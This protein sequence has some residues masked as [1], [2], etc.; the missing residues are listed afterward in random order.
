MLL[1]SYSKI[2]NGDQI[3]WQRRTD[4]LALNSKI[5]VSSG[6]SKYINDFMYFDCKNILKSNA[7]SPEL[8]DASWIP[9]KNDKEKTIKFEFALNQN[10]S[11]IKIYQNF[12]S[13]KLVK[14]I[15]VKVNECTKNFNLNGLI[16]EIAIEQ[17]NVKFIEIKILDKLV[18]NE[19][20]SEIEIFSSSPSR[21]KFMTILNDDNFVYNKYYYDKIDLKIYAYDGIK[22]Y[23]IDSNDLIFYQDNNKI[24]YDDLIKTKKKKFRLKIILKDDL[25]TYYEVLFIKVNKYIIF[26]NKII[27][28]TNILVVNINIFYNRVINKLRKIIHKFIYFNKM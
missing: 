2:I 15:S 4:N 20:F 17:D 28:L 25:K 13:N 10:V 23:Y 18:K 5:S 22:S 9:Q 26:K 16:S 12:N 6:D 27:N 21:Y 24:D 14:N 8:D 3:F 1:E 11:T 7:Q 19:G